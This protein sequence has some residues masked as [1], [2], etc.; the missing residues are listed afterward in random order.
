MER[1][2]E[3]KRDRVRRLLIN[4]LEASGMR[5]QTRMKEPDYSEMLIRLADKLSYL[6]DLMLEG[7]VTWCTRHAKG[8]ERNQW[9]DEVA[10]L[11]QAM[12]LQP[13]P[14]RSCPYVVSVLRSQAGD[15][16]EMMGYLTELFMAAKKYGPP[17]SK[18]NLDRLAR[19]AQENS[20]EV[21]KVQ[22]AIRRGV[23]LNERR[24]WLDW[25]LRHQSDALAIRASDGGEVAA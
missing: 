12:S 24:Q 21:A 5:K 13:P 22:D 20:A 15:R 19:E 3:T 17:F 18:M 9:P 14:P 6:P 4:P 10:I 1:C 7:L 23:A 2:E 11:S 25:Y 8:K 16:A